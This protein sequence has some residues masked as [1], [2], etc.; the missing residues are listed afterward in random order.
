VGTRVTLSINGVYVLDGDYK[1]LWSPT[2]TFDDDKTIVL[3]SGHVSMGSSSV[4]TNFTV[5]EAKYG[6]YYVGFMNLE[7]GERLDFQ[8]FVGPS[9]KVVPSSAKVGATVTIT[10]AG[11]PSE[12]AG[13]L[14][15]DS[16]SPSIYVKT[17]KIGSFTTVFTI[18]DALSGEHALIVTM[19]NMS[20]EPVDTALE[21]LPNAQSQPE[22]PRN[23]AE[24]PVSG[25]EAGNSSVV[26][27]M[28]DRNPPPPPAAISPMG[29]SFGL[30]GTKSVTF[31]WT[32]V[33]DPSGV[34]YTL[35]VASDCNFTM[36]KPG[37]RI[38]GLTGTSYTV[39]VTPGTYYW[40]VKA[41]DGAGNESYWAYSPYAF[42]V[43]ELSCFVGEFLNFLGFW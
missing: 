39:D 10:G 14:S 40:R 24:V 43:A 41:V 21:V 7:T 28:P 35:E 27:S 33:S 42:K 29:H 18:P 32:G 34:S 6:M 13:I 2:A 23:N 30:L 4:V 8:F 5:P 3:T 25:S 19:S 36:I 11:F 37:M 12:D 22:L 31:T 16:K 20:I 15:F 1:V 9:L 38:S 26:V 17:N